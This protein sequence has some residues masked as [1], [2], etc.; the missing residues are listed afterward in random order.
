MKELCRIAAQSVGSQS[1]VEVTKLPEGN[2]TKALLLRMDDG[3]ECVAKIPNSNAGRAHFLTASEVATM[4]FVSLLCTLPLR[5]N[6]ATN[7]PVSTGQKCS[8]HTSP[9]SVFLEL[10]R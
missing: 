2:F 8:G 6:C 5:N 10:K 9:E 4:E 3:K 7:M 1:C